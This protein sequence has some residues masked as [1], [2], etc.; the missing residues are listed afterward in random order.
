MKK[1]QKK[2]KIPLHGLLFAS[3]HKEPRAQESR[4]VRGNEN[5]IV[6]FDESRVGEHFA[7]GNFAESSELQECSSGVKK[8]VFALMC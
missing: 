6:T 5:A 2:Q 8:G 7:N 3:L 1:E 4:E